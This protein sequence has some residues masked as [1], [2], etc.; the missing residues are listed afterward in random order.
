MHLS[1]VQHGAY[2]L[3]IMAYWRAAAPLPDD[4]AFL[5]ACAKLSVEE[6]RGYRTA[7]SQF[8]VIGLGVWR[9][10]RID[11]ELIK[12]KERLQAKSDAGVKGNKKR[13][14]DRKRIA[15]GSQ[16]GSQA[17]SQTDRERIASHTPLTEEGTAPALR[18]GQSR[19][20][21]SGDDHR[22]VSMAEIRRR[23]GPPPPL[24]MPGPIIPKEDADAIRNGTYNSRR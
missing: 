24:R 15:K 9:H 16:Q 22:P 19:L 10:K 14:G 4:D 21:G 1:T 3:L 2:L 12:A 23:E 7:M 6:W 18:G 17:A 13:W 11:K 8:F 5:A 20:T